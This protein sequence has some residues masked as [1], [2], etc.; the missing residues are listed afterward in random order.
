MGR[1]TPSAGT[2]YLDSLEL[3]TSHIE[4]AL[5]FFTDRKAE[6]LVAGRVSA[7][8]WAYLEYETACRVRLF[9]EERG[10]RASGRQ[11]RGEVRSLLADHLGLV[12]CD[13][14]FDELA[15]LANGV[16][17]DSRVIL[18]ARGLHPSRADRFNSD[19][20]RWKDVREPFLKDMT[21]A[22]AEAQVPV[23]LG[24]HSVVAGGLMAL[25]ESM[26]LSREVT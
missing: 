10:M 3:D 14:F 24:G 12:G 16:L 22:A 17:L 11:A 2:S 6:V 18:A 23:V 26:Q 21:R 9:S 7:S 1:Y 8:T 5:E 19:L 13:G 4:Q 15:Q 25:L 20:L